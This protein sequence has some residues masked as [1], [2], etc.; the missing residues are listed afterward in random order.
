MASREVELWQSFVDMFTTVGDGVHQK[1]VRQRE[2]Y[3]P[4]ELFEGFNAFLAEL[5]EPQREILAK[6]LIRARHSGV[7]DTIAVL[8][9]R[10]ALN[11]GKYS[12]G[13]IEMAFEPHG[14]KLYEDFIRREA[15]DEWPTAP[16]A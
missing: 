6:M 12:E 5:T 4:S 9:D 15:G 1:W 16:D 3:P 11:N 8:H 13:G 2:S 10:F 7:I 14:Y